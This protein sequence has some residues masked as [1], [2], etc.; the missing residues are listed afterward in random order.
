[1]NNTSFHFEKR[2]FRRFRDKLSS[3]AKKEYELGL[4]NLLERYNT[5]IYENRFLV[6]GVV[7]IFTMA[8]LRSTGIEVDSCGS[9]AVGG[10]LMLP[11][12][13]MFSVK[14]SFA[15][16]RGAIRLIN[17]MGS[18][19]T[20]W[21]TATL[22]ILSNVGI[23]YGDPSMVEDGDLNRKDDVLTINR[24][25]I[26]RFA[27]DTSNLIVMNIPFKPPAEE[28]PYSDKAS[29]AVAKQLMYDLNLVNLINEMPE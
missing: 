1:M 14:S 8:L 16:G 27:E 22:F 11:D 21:E 3:E 15:E 18:S 19:Y 12:G 4:K 20:A 6:G 5:T 23:V 7:E 29:T 26:D 28:V 9:E 25:A 10:D 13:K 24:N 17:T 2:Y